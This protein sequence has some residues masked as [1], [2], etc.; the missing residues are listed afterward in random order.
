[1]TRWLQAAQRAK[2]APTNL[3]PADKTDKTDKTPPIA[4]IGLQFAQTEMVL[5]VLSVLSED[6][7]P[8]HQ[9]KVPALIRLDEA[10]SPGLA[11]DA[12]RAR[13]NV[14]GRPM[15][16]TGRVVSL[17]AWRRLSAWEQHGPAGR[18]FC[19]VC[20]AWVAPRAFPYCHDGGAA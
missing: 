17:D 8:R 13:C 15:T 19:G 3:H 12:A 14:T 2:V 20:R 10:T 18:L 11:G 5:S 16:W 6:C 7:I 4:E 9:C 1:M